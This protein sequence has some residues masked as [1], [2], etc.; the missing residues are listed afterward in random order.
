M[1]WRRWLIGIP[2][3]F[4]LLITG[5]WWE[6]NWRGARMLEKS[7]AALRGMGEPLELSE[8]IR[9][10][11]DELNIAAAPIFAE[12]FT[13][14]STEATRL[15]AWNAVLYSAKK[16]RAPGKQPE[17]IQQPKNK[18]ISPDD[19]SH[20]AEW[21]IFL[22]RALLPD[23]S[24]D[25]APSKKP[26]HT[27]LKIFSRWD[28]EK[29]EIRLALQRPQCHWPTELSATSIPIHS[30]LPILGDFAELQRPYI[31]ACA[32]RGDASEYV[33]GMVTLMRLGLVAH[34]QL[35]SLNGYSYATVLDLTTFRIWQDSLGMLSL[36]DFQ[37]QELQETVIG[38]SAKEFEST[39]RQVHV[40]G[41][42]WLKTLDAEQI[43]M[44]FI[45]PPPKALGF[46]GSNKHV[47]DLWTSAVAYRPR[48]W[49]LAEVAMLQGFRVQT[50]PILR[51]WRTNRTT[52][53]SVGR[54]KSCIHDLAAQAGPFSLL[55]QFSEASESYEWNAV[56]TAGRQ[57]MAHQ[58]TLWCA[59]E[60]YKLRHGHVPENLD[61]ISAFLPGGSKPFDPV[62]GEPMRYIKKS[63]RDYLLYSIAWNLK[64]EG[65]LIA[66]KSTLAGDW[67]WASNP[68]FLEREK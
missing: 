47:T 27:M 45:I 22:R 1:K 56:R 10:V 60:R 49:Q 15:G 39:L 7:N 48:G 68:K 42:A 52:P 62:N 4:A 12:L 53:A 29:H 67:T 58:A 66:K 11:P 20:L 59:I 3:A 43:R 25:M 23:I 17:R 54:I 6:E 57:A 16:Q 24:G 33:Q 37:L 50:L 63:D 38:I 8:V 64:D 46:L 9:P 28:D 18:A 65:G 26:E 61:A 19:L 35:Y 40:H 51:E 14:Q 21:E 41:A 34:R 32:A 30:H 5:L 36:N 31:L 55:S 2:L 13:G 44:N